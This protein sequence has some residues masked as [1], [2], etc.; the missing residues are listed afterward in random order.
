M[1]QVM[2]SMNKVWTRTTV[3]P[4]GDAVSLG[5][6]ESQSRLWENQIGRTP[7]FW[8]VVMAEFKESFPDAPSWDRQR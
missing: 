6:H 2:R 7:E 8:N 1:K 4:R 5:V 3:L